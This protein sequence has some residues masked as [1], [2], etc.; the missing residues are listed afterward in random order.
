VLLLVVGIGLWRGDAREERRPPT[1][2]EPLR[3]VSLAPS[4]TDIVIEL[5]RGDRLVGVTRYCEGADP[6]IAR[7]GD[8]RFDLETVL[9]LDPDLVLAIE[10]RSQAGLRAALESRGIAVEVYPAESVEDVRAALSGL[11]ALLGAREAAARSLERI[12]S[13]LEPPAGEPIR[14]VFVVERQSLTVAGG[15][16]F[17][18]AMLRAAGIENAYGAEPWSYRR[19]EL[20]ALIALD[21]VI[22]LDASFDLTEPAAFWGRFPSLRAVREGRVRPFPPVRPGIGIPAWVARLREEARVGRE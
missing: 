20:E 5:G 17:V 7:V 16:S 10:T 14:G 18:D 8:L 1:P 6:R 13:A 19:V 21:P 22:I 15:G 3:I 4:L 12:D 9:A 2:G 11:G